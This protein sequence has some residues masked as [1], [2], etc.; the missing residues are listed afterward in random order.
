VTALP[1]IAT[2]PRMLALTAER[3]GDAPAIDDEG[4]VLSWRS[5]HVLVR[6]AA[7]A[8]I[9]LGVQPGDRV[10]VWAPNLHEWIV[11]ALGAQSVGGVLVPVSTRMKGL[12]AADV[13]QQSRARVLVSIGEFLD[14]YYPDLLKDQPLPDL[15]ATVVLR[16]AREGDLGW[17]AFLAKADAVPE[18]ALAQ[19]EAAIGPD[20]LSDILYT[21]GTT[22]RPKGVMTTHGQNLRAFETWSGVL[23]MHGDDRYLVINPFFHSAGYKAGWMAALIR[24]A[25]IVPHQV[26]EAEQ[27]LRRIQ[28]ERISFLLGPPTLFLT[29]LSHPQVADFDLTSLRVAVTG[30]ATVPPV[31]VRRMREELG[32]RTVVTAYGLTECCGFAT[33]CDPQDDA[34]TIANTCGHAIPGVE[35][36][37]ADAEGRSVPAG[38]PGEVLIRGYNVMQG[39]LENEAATRQAIDAE[40]WLHTGD[41]GVMDERGYLRITDRLKDMYIVGGFNCYPAEIERLAA[42]HPA[43]AQIAVIGV[44]DERQGEVGRAFLVLRPGATLDAASFIAWCRQHMTNYKVPRHVDILAGLP[45][46]ATGKV[47][48]LALRQ[49]PL[50]ANA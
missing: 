20:S 38:E 7:R 28:S 50:P 40:G 21:S 12:E 29:L 22:G 6:R 35:V 11:A 8:F 19:R 17:E 4:Q 26:F 32:F 27:I 31:L 18:A 33:I 5:L 24:G 34:E 48:K 13:L 14:R 30:A 49:R 46:N 10:A 36:R 23:G 37:C 39:Y 25:L 41:V 43:V 47:D 2:L 1:E 9:A 3:Q 44:P 45:L 15:R 42:A 16:S